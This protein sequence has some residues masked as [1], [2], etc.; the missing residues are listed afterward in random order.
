[1]PTSLEVRHHAPI[2]NVIRR[3][4]KHLRGCKVFKRLPKTSGMRP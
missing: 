3:C 2:L 1:M 4:G